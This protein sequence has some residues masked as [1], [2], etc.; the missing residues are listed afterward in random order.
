MGNFL[1]FLFGGFR[2]L[3]YLCNEIREGK[4]VS[5]IPSLTLSAK[6]AL[7]KVKNAII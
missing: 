4:K 2:P 7:R 1:L 3:L 5:L 6:Y